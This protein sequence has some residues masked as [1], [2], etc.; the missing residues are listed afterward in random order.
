MISTQ[1]LRP[2]ILLLLSICYRVTSK[3]N[4][5]TASALKITLVYAFYFRSVECLD[6]CKSFLKHLKFCF[7]E[8]LF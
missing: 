3:F 6:F 5:L 2:F 7:R 1:K 8:N 4:E